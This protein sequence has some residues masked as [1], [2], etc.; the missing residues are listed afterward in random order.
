MFVY[1]LL[2]FAAL[3]SARL[4]RSVLSHFPW[5]VSPNRWAVSFA[6]FLALTV[7]PAIGVLVFDCSPSN[8]VMQKYLPVALVAIIAVYTISTFK[9]LRIVWTFALPAILVDVAVMALIWQA[10][11]LHHFLTL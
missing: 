6:A 2:V 7:N 8:V 3:V 9:G 5:A 11:L 10:T 4:T 1:W